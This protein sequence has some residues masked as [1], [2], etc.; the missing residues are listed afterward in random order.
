MLEKCS[1]PE[2]DDAK[3]LEKSPKPE[4]VGESDVEMPER[5]LKLEKD[6]EKW[7]QNVRKK[8]QA[9]ESWRKVISIRQKE[10]TGRQESAKSELIISLA[11]HRKQPELKYQKIQFY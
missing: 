5:S 9:R 2:K 10:A 7:F 4:K 8:C 11:M 1:K 6:R 3:T